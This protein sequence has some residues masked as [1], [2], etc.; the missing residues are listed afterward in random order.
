MEHPRNPSICRKTAFEPKL[1]SIQEQF[2]VNAV[3]Y[4]YR[5][6]VN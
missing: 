2:R 3:F 4:K 1:K 5:V 6:R